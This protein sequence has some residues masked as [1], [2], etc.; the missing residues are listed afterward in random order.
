GDAGAE[1]YSCAAAEDRQQKGFGEELDADV[2]PGG[3]ECTA[4]PDFG[5]ALEHGDHHG[6]GNADAAH[7]QGDGAE[8]EQQPGEGLVG[9]GLGGE[10]VGRPGHVDLVGLRRVGGP[11]EQVA[12]GF[13]GVGGG[14]GV[15]GRDVGVGAEVALRGGPAD[16]RAQVELG[17]ERNRA[18]DADDGEPSLA[19]PVLDVSAG[20]AHA[21]VFG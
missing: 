15:D 20:G 13:D 9:G 10:R 12:N 7:E 4:Q 5:A 2:L 21:V 16:Q 17:R 14:P 19:E 6:V 8:A 18:Q 1:Q 11:G 3:A